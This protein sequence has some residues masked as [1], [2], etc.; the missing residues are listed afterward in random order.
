MYNNR[1]IFVTYKMG[2]IQ[3]VGIKRKTLVTLLVFIVTLGFSA[4]VY[5]KADSIAVISAEFAES[6]LN[7]WYGAEISSF[8]EEGEVIDILQYDDDWISFMGDSGVEYIPMTNV[9]ILQAEGLICSNNVMLLEEPTALANVAFSVPMGSVVNA[10]GYY[11]DFYAVDLGGISVYVHKN[12]VLG[13][14]LGF[15]DEYGPTPGTVN[16]NYNTAY[17]FLDDTPAYGNGDEYLLVCNTN[18]GLNLRTSPS[19]DAPILASISNGETLDIIELGDEWHLVYY[20]NLSGFV[21]AKYTVHYSGGDP[22]DSPIYAD[23]AGSQIVAYAK[24]YIG[25]K[26]KW[27]GTNLNSGV[28]CSGFVYSI[29]KSAGITLNRS[30]KDQIKNGTVVNKSELVPGDLVFFATSGGKSISHVGIYIGNG[31]FIHSSSS[32]KRGVII[33]NLTDGYY[34]KTYVSACRVLK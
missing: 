24:Q 17:Y 16:F 11:G 28:D 5:V 8:F 10:I 13:G 18:N 1:N 26:Y 4:G 32:G 22:V 9:T 29:Y 2:D 30:S 3:T 14:L 12:D 19:A 7:P 33:S 25:T 34:A 31:D 23:G 15:L 21:S 20:G 6:Y 27:G